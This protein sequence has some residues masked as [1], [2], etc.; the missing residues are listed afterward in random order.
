[1]TVI[2]S[3][4]STIAIAGRSEQ[5]IRPAV[6]QWP[7]GWI[8]GLACGLANESAQTCTCIDRQRPARDLLPFELLRAPSG[9]GSPKLKAAVPQGC[10]GSE[11]EGNG[12]QLA[13]RSDGRPNCSSTVS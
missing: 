10:E 4:I 1:M 2:I 8:C 13:A 9:P 11:R 3:I 5:A 6:T 7:R 12:L